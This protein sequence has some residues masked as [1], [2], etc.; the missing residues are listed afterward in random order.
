MD[1]HLSFLKCLVYNVTH[2]HFLITASDQA[3][4]PNPLSWTFQ[5]SVRGQWESWLKMKDL[6][7]SVFILKLSD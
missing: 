5:N 2:S 1:V 3:I 4:A 7:P 6:P